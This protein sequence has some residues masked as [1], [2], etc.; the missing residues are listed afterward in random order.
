MIKSFF[1]S[2]E[3]K[4]WAWSGLLLLFILT[5]GQVQLTVL[6]N[7]WYGEFYN[8][9]QKANNIDAFW[10]SILKFTYIAIPFIFVAMLSFYFAQHYALKWREAITYYYL[11]LWEKSNNES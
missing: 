9:L 1:Y 7:E 8:I 4:I 6:I 5:W 3:Y 2:S 10:N 11:P